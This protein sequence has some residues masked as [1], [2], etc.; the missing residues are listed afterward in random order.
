MS[1]R[2]LLLPFTDPVSDA[3]LSAHQPQALHFNTGPPSKTRPASIQLP[4]FCAQ[5]PLSP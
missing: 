4:L 1:L 2:P 5:S 3:S